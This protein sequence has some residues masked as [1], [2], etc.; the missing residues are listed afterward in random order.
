MKHFLSTLSLAAVVAAHGYVDN[1]TIGGQVYT[2]YQPYSDPYQNPPIPRVSREI[3]GNGPVTD[4]SYTDHQCGGYTDGGISGSKPA[5]LHAEAAAG[6]EVSLRWTLWPDSHVG[7]LVTY[8]ARCPDTGCNAYMPGSSYVFLSAYNYKL[9][10]C[11]VL[12]GSRSR[13]KVGQE[14][15]IPGATAL[16]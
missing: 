14:R 1:A 13:K 7:P 15:P 9:M 11:V 10:P 16:S 8:M 2:F 4:V 12:C 6:S 3:Q 5:S